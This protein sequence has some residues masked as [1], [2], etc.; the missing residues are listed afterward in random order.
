M[1]ISKSIN[2]LIESFSGDL[3]PWAFLVVIFILVAGFL[4]YKKITKPSETVSQK[5]IN[6]RNVAARDIKI[7]ND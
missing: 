2:S 3:P 4:V 5:N 7:R 1:D 6:A